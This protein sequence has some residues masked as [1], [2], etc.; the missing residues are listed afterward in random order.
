MRA[1]PHAQQQGGL[2]GA[3]K[4]A[5]PAAAA[6]AAPGAAAAA[7]AGAAGGVGG[8]SGGGADAAASRRSRHMSKAEKQAAA[9]VG[10]GGRGR[11]CAVGE[12]CTGGKRQLRHRGCGR[13][14][15]PWPASCPVMSWGVWWRS[16][17]G[18]GRVLPPKIGGI[19]LPR[20]GSF[21]ERL[22][23]PHKSTSWA[24]QPCH[25]RC[26]PAHRELSQFPGA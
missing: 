17:E 1:P 23:G 4:G 22:G 21:P 11:W 20:A 12:W 5:A 25:L 8:P 10:A 16:G 26:R 7:A 18:C 14:Q 6:G 24:A 9:E 19:T 15:G 2:Q 3:G 13:V